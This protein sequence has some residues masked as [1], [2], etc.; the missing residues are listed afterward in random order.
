MDCNFGERLVNLISPK[1]R[2]SKNK[3]L[4]Q[5]ANATKYIP[6]WLTHKY[7]DINTI[8]KKIKT[9]PALQPKSTEDTYQQMLKEKAPRRWTDLNNLKNFMLCKKRLILK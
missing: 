6:N 2:G 5:I 7:L 4:K 3:I 1:Y 9:I 8:N